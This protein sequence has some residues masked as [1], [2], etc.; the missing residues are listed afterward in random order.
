MEPITRDEIFMATAA[1]E[2][3]GEL[4]VSIPASYRSRLRA[5]NFTG[6]KLPKELTRV[7]ASLQNLL[8]QRLK[9]I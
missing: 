1:G 3:S 2:Y 6:R 8:T 4:P 7:A 5:Q 9:T